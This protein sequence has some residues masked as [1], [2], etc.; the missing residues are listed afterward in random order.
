MKKE[1]LHLLIDEEIYSIGEV[2]LGGDSTGEIEASEGEEES[3]KLKV[4]SDGQQIEENVEEMTEKS[5]AAV[6]AEEENLASKV[7]SD[8]SQVEGDAEESIE[9]PALVELI[10][11]ESQKSIVTN[12]KQQVE[13][14]TAESI[15]KPT[16][17]ES[18]E[19]TYSIPSVAKPEPEPSVKYAFF[20]NTDQPEEL[21][22]LN[23]VIAACKLDTSDF[24]VLKVGQETA[25]EKAVVF[26]KSG[27]SYYK[28]TNHEK[29][30]V[31][32]SQPLSVLANSKEEKGK[33]WGALQGFIN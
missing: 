5:A 16:F 27:P 33:L 28:S 30:I 22:L 15:E 7:V 26:T 12:D 8:K 4:E 9:S 6:P 31:M 17:T 25:F 21:D 24:K 14:T 3:R 13:E 29:G 2:G 1:H 10:D 19:E 20:H 32:Y 18:S 11:E 23:K